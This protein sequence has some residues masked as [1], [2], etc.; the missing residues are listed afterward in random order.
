MYRRKVQSSALE[1]VGYDAKK[2]I[3][4]LEFREHSDVWQYFGIR[5]STY[6]KFISSES[7]GKYFV[8]RI[9][10]KYPELKLL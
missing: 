8:T 10:G 6:K 1:S 4:E 3:L 2:Q 9:K 7:L 5:P